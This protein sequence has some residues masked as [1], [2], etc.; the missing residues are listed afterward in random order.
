M[1]ICIIDV[2]MYSRVSTRPSTARLLPYTS[3]LPSQLLYR[4]TSLIRNLHFVGPCS[5]P[6]PR[7]I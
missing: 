6:M 1:Y 5:S 2:C 7:V 4:G 3:G